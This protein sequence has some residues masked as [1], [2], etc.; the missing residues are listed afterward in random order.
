MACIL[1]EDIQDDLY[2]PVAVE[3]SRYAVGCLAARALVLAKRGPPNTAMFTGLDAECI[4]M[5]MVV[6]R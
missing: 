1:V 5:H 4:Q 3:V 2:A 6:G